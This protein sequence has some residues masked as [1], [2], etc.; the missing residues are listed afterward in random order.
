VGDHV[1]WFPT[2]NTLGWGDGT[3]MPPKIAGT[4]T[5]IREVEGGHTVQL[6]Q[7]SSSTFP[8]KI[9]TFSPGS[10]HG[11]TLYF[12]VGGGNKQAYF[13]Y[14]KF[15]PGGTPAT[16]KNN[17]QAISVQRLLTRIKD[18]NPQFASLVHDGKQKAHT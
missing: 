14:W 7:T 1:G 10:L 4:V 2:V 11:T 9:H 12:G 17:R 5:Y 18:S 13:Q 16:D 8:N 3:S 15:V 6:R